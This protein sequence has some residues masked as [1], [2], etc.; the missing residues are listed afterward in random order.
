MCVCVGGNICLVVRTISNESNW[1]HLHSFGKWICTIIVTI[2]IDRYHRFIQFPFAYFISSMWAYQY[3]FSSC[4]AFLR[5]FVLSKFQHWT[6][7]FSYLKK[8][9]AL[10]IWSW[11][12]KIRR[13]ITLFFHNFVLNKMVNERE[14]DFFEHTHRKHLLI[15]WRKQMKNTH[16]A[17]SSFAPS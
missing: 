9:F 14:F 3:I 17:Y 2:P 5:L 8:H 6:E 12:M 4:W 15:S 13:W 11:S 10:E 1:S 7:I 16:E